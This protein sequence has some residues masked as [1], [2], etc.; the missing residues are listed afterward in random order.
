M[1]DP[2]DR[3]SVDICVVGAGAAG[4][5]AAARAARLGRQVLLVEKTPRTGT[6]ILASGGTRCNVTTS[7]DPEEATRLFGP[8][9]GR[10]LRPAFRTLPPAAVRSHLTSLGVPTITAPLDKVF[11]TSGRATDVRDALERDARQAGA[12]ILCHAAVQGIG[13]EGDRWVV[14]LG[15]GRAVAFLRSDICSLKS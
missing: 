14:R 4:L 11:P 7:L 6:K 8:R 1:P 15:D 3:L 9:G 2:T 10:F 12:E 5:W 13:T